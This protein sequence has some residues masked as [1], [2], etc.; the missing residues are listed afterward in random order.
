M[1]RIQRAALAAATAVTLIV[2]WQV[3]PALGT[4]G[5]DFTTPAGIEQYLFSIG[6]DPAEAVF[7]V[8]PLN[9]AGPDCPGLAWNCTTALDRPIVQITQLNG[10]NEVECSPDEDD[11]HAVQAGHSGNN[12]ARCTQSSHENPAA[13]SCIITQ[14]TESERGSNRAVVEQVI[15]QSGDA[16]QDA[17]QTAMITQTSVN[18]NNSANVDQRIKQSTNETTL[19]TQDAKQ[20]L[21]LTQEAD[22]GDNSAVVNQSQT[23][24]ATASSAGNPITQEQNAAPQGPSACQTV[25]Y[26]VHLFLEPNACSAVQQLTDPAEGGRNDADVNQAIDQFANARA[27]AGTLITQQQSSADGGAE[28]EHDQHGAAPATLVTDQDERQT[29]KPTTGTCPPVCQVQWGP[30]AKGNIQEDNPF[31]VTDITQFSMQDASDDAIQNMVLE[32][33]CVTTGECTIEQVAI[34]NGERIE[35]E[36]VC[37]PAEEGTFCESTVACGPFVTEEDCFPPPAVD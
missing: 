2:G 23:Q 37:T 24:D 14:E 22:Q 35:G 1:T 6:V 18:G 8:G 28:I 9:Y 27:P 20:E 13:Q 34:Q 11:C 12:L 32:A 21:K 16:E 17:E 3:A 31:N 5:P 10:T 19:Q 15:I 4:T 26:T 7:Q 29:L 36:P 25:T 30:L 33:N